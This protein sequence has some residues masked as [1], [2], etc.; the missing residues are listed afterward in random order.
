MATLAT[1]D[2]VF[3]DENVHDFGEFT[4]PNEDSENES[5]QTDEETGQ[6]S[7]GSSAP[8]PFSMVYCEPHASSLAGIRILVEE[9]LEKL[10]R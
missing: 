7:A 10:R 6:S 2:E 4:V 5:D 8:E 1:G 9:R 3:V